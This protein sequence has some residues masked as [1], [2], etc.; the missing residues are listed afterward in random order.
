MIIGHETL[1]PCFQK[2]N[3]DWLWIID[4]LDGTGNFANQNPLFSVCIALMEKQELI[5][6]TIYAPVINEF[7]FGRE[8]KRS[9]FQ[10]KKDWGFGGF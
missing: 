10:S 4:S 7:L 5:L 1:C 6:G 3:S 2:A 9:L 8:G